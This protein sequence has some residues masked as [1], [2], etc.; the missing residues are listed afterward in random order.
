MR[1]PPVA[2][3][4]SRTRVA[5][6]FLRILGFF[7]CGSGVALHPETLKNPVAPVALQLPVVW[8]V[9]PPLKRCR[10]TGL[11]ISYTCG[12]RATLCNYGPNFD[13]TSPQG[14]KIKPIS[15]QNQVKAGGPHQVGVSSAWG[16]GSS[17][18]EWLCSSAKI[19]DSKECPREIRTERFMF[20][21]LWGVSKPGGFP[22]FSGKVQIVSRTLSGLF[23]VGAL[24]RPR[25]R[26]KGRIGKIPGPSPEQLGKIPEKSGN[27][28]KGQ[29]RTKKEGH[30]QIGK[31]PHGKHNFFLLIPS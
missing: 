17:R 31:P 20:L 5:A 1:R 6:D 7:R 8:H 13:P 19:C 14:V 16:W 9:K 27:S 21:L 24:N 3:H 2:L 10:A 15:G 30:V 4:V 26:K 29:K 22:L 23:L 11:F 18:L 25:K 28:Q 12:C